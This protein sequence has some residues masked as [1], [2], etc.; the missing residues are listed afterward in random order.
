LPNRQCEDR[1]CT[2]TNVWCGSGKKRSEE[3]SAA[4][5][6]RFYLCHYCRRIW[7]FRRNFHID[8][9][10]TA[11][12]PVFSSQQK[13]SKFIWK[14]PCFWTWV[15]HHFSGIYQYGRGGRD[16]PD[17]RTATAFGQ[18]GWYIYLDDV[19]VIGNYSQHF[20]EGRTGKTTA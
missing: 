3:F 8:C 17:N 9:L 5:I 1:H 12:V 20:T 2:R 19:C 11:F 7:F 18:F 15:F 14:I 6:I 13:S 4:I 16:F 10:C